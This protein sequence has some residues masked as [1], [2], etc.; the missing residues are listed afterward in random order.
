M[1]RAHSKDYIK[2]W[3]DYEEEKEQQRKYMAEH[4]DPRRTY[5]VKY[6]KYGQ[7]CVEKIAALTQSEAIEICK[8]GWWMLGINV[9]VV[10]AT[11]IEE[12]EAEKKAAAKAEKKEGLP[13]DG[14]GVQN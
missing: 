4:G 13:D 7:E 2:G 9:D 5:E 3:A 6:I 11:M 1:A 12:S 8:N 10:K 14:A